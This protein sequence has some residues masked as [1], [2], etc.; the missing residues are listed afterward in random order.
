MS[1]GGQNLASPL[2]VTAQQLSRFLE[3]QLPKIGK[4]DW[5]NT[6]VTSQLSYGQQGQVRSR[7]ITTIGG[8]DLAAL[9]RVFEKNWAELSYHAKL[10]GET[11]THAR[12]IADLR[13]ANAHA[14]SDG[15]GPSARNLY[16]H[17]DTLERFLSAI[18]AN[19]EAIKLIEQQ[20]LNTLSQLSPTK[21]NV[22]APAPATSNQPEPSP[23]PQPESQS[24]QEE[25]D[26]GPWAGLPKHEIGPLVIC[27]PGEPIEAEVPSFGGIPVP[28]TINPW[29][30]TGANSLE[31][32]IHVI[33]VDDDLEGGE[34][35][36]VYCDSRN[37]SP[38]AWDDVVNRLR[39]GIR[40]L[41][42]GLLTMDL[43]AA[44]RA[45]GARAAR[46]VSTLQELDELAGIDVKSTLKALGAEAYG[47]REEI[48][49]ESNKCR[50]WPAATF[51][52]DDLVTPAAAWMIS[53]LLPVL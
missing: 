19:E 33:L 37:N 4:D 32:T 30:V 3:E 10:S 28:A 49:G 31:F 23:S 21:P 22:Q 11:R 46:H 9:L 20:R 51:S 2:G 53:T 45:S 27:G 36:Q 14:A 41:D 34:Y 15:I 16:R 6:H 5:W 50:K 25:T 12:E 43:R 40:K 48:Y 29:Q 8:L 26:Q 47:T 44:T 24:P 17:L 52:A 42:D 35:G 7:N 18:E 13:H 39:V 38:Q 1:N